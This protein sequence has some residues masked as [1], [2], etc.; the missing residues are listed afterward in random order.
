[1]R[2]RLIAAVDRFAIGEI[3]A[4]YRAVWSGKIAGVQRPSDDVILTHFRYRATNDWN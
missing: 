4:M 1:V 3:A 2:S